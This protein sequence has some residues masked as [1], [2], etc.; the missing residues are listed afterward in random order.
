MGGETRG[1]VIFFECWTL[2]N[3]RQRRTKGEKRIIF[4]SVFMSVCS[5]STEEKE[6]EDVCTQ[7]A[8]I[9]VAHREKREATTLT[10]KHELIL[11]SGARADFPNEEA[12]MAFAGFHVAFTTSRHS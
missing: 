12:V 9:V 6:I 11:I 10:P 8:F 5:S 7:G 4:S 1:K 3:N 2:E